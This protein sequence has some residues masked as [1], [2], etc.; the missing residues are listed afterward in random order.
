MVIAINI[1]LS[2]TFIIFRIIGVFL[3]E[4]A[5]TTTNPLFKDLAHLY[6]G[7]LFGGWLFS[8]K[9]SKWFRDLF[10]IMGVVELTCF[11][12]GVIIK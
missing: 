3:P 6:E 7:F 9:Y 2:L 1:C 11:I 8:E 4:F 10:I 12:L 5:W